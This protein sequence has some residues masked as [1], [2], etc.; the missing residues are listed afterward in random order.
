MLFSKN[1]SKYLSLGETSLS[2]G[3]LYTI[4]TDKNA[5]GKKGAIVTDRFHV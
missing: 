2:N 4:L 3:E 1:L 5:K